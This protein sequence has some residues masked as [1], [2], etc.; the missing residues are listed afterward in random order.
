VTKR[1]RVQQSEHKTG[2]PPSGEPE[3][4]VVG[5]LRRPHGLKG[6]LLMEILTDF[7]ERLQPDK[8]VFVGE[9]K[10]QH[11]IRRSRMHSGALLV[12]F[13]GYHDPE[14]AGEFR[15]TLVY[16]RADDRPPLQEGE[17]Y[18]HQ[19]IGLNV[20]SDDGQRLGTLSQIITTGANDVY[21]V[22]TETG[23]DILLPAIESVILDIDIVKGLVRVKLPPG[24][25]PDQGKQGSG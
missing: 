11:R 19:I 14:S 20:I 15:N 7:P 5:K 23:P 12:T 16:V 4:L 6:E 3:F 8:V 21:V 1:G 22:R 17:Y 10:I 9:E 13:A 2:S 25:V 24:L 18:H